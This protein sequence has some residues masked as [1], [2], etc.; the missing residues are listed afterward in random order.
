MFVEVPESKSFLNTATLPM[1][2]TVVG[3]ALFAKLLMMVCVSE[4]LDVGF[5]VQIKIHPLLYGAVNS[6]LET[7]CLS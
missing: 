7:L 4:L 1:Y 6:V 2:L 5:K 3:T